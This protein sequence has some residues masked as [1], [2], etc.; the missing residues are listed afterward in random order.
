MLTFYVLLL[1]IRYIYVFIYSV[2][3]KY[4][5]Y[6]ICFVGIFLLVNIFIIITPS[7]QK[8]A[9]FITIHP[10]VVWKKSL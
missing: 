6:I 9:S 8:Y 5:I 2:G 4:V 7:I 3:I 10:K 1:S